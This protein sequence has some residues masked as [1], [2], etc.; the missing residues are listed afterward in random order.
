VLTT[1]QVLSTLGL[2]DDRTKQLEEAEQVRPETVRLE[3]E[4]KGVYAELI[5][6]EEQLELR[7]KIHYNSNLGGDLSVAEDGS[8]LLLPFFKL[9]KIAPVSL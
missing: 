9:F 6:I 8:S 4:L 5:K 1:L 3:R 7:E 2:K